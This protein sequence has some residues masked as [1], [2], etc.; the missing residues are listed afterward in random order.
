ML[1]QEDRPILVSKSIEQLS[2]HS[3]QLN[4]IY[5]KFFSNLRSLKKLD[6]SNNLLITLFSKPLS[7]SKNLDFL[8]L[9]GNLWQCD[10]DLELTVAYL[11]EKSVKVVNDQ[12]EKQR[13][14]KFERMQVAPSAEIPFHIPIEKKPTF[15]NEIFPVNVRTIP[16]HG[17]EDE[18][19]KC[20]RRIEI[21]QDQ[22]HE[23]E[24]S[25]LSSDDVYFIFFIGVAMG[26]I[27]I[28][29]G[30]TCCIC[31]HKMC[32]KSFYESEVFV[33]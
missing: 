15:F 13:P 31:I 32:R 23:M 7:Y 22:Y 25:R 12:C 26:V 9:S 4:H 24:L 20:T 6:L 11:K 30:I 1:W 14:V 19:E 17:F 29:L 2:L 28:M 3:S 10:R 5:P 27:G 33:K 16:N 8:N 21:L 18:Y